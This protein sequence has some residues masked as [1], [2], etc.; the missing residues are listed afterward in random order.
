MREKEVEG[1][2]Y[3]WWSV[4]LLQYRLPAVPS[5]TWDIHTGHGNELK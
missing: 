5:P 4:V 1:G 2:N 3:Q